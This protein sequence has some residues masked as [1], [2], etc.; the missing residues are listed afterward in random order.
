[1]A[2]VTIDELY[3]DQP[4]MQR[5]QWITLV[6]CA[7]VLCLEGIDLA[8]INFMAP[9][10]VEDLGIPMPSMGRVFSAGYVGL[11]LGGAVIAPLGDRWGRK[12]LLL[13]SMVLSG[14]GCLFTM[15][16]T[17]VTELMICRLVTGMG[18]GASI[19]VVIAL[20]S[21]TVPAA[22]RIRWVTIVSIGFS[23]GASVTAPLAVALLPAFGWHGIFA[24]GAGMSLVLGLAIL[25]MLHESA[26]WLVNKG[27]RPEEVRRQARRLRPDLTISDDTVIVGTAQVASK[28]NV[29]DL[30][31]GGRA[32]MTVLIWCIFFIAQGTIYTTHSWVPSVLN[33]AGVSLTVIGNAGVAFGIGSIIGPLVAS[34]LMERYGSYKVLALTFLSSAI[35]IPALYLAG[36]SITAFVI[37]YTII[38]GSLGA[39]QIGLNVVASGAYPPT[40][41]STG[42]GWAQAM[43]RF[44]AILGPLLGAGLL[45]LE[46]PGISVFFAAAAGSI[47]AGLLLL[48]AVRRFGRNSEYV[49]APAGDP[50]AGE[51]A[52][53]PALAET[54]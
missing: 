18:I 28:G 32:G 31:V 2:T 21:D 12:P 45:A 5:G 38:G 50:E 54:R 1:M 17:S 44:G 3:N 23:M 7:L 43:G 42:L 16:S 40:L 41:R 53:Q 15:W 9:R 37:A 10:I 20:V 24:V 49:A 22:S 4:R 34:Q 14:L 33:L 46:L 29:K 39:G 11:M 25:F 26:R 51:R 35:F 13:I 6:L 27:R 47:L 48:L 36:V 8:S 52:A 30:F 19:P